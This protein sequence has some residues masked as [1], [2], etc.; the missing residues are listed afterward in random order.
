MPA[1]YNPD[2]NPTFPKK[3]EAIKVYNFAVPK[4]PEGYD[5]TPP[6]GS[7]YLILILLVTTITH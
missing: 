7:L 2:V 6:K 3:E 5:Y 1:G 4:T